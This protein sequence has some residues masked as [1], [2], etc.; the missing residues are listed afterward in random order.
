MRVSRFA[1]L[2]MGIWFHTLSVVS[3]WPDSLHHSMRYWKLTFQV[4]SIYMNSVIVVSRNLDRIYEEGGRRHYF[5]FQSSSKDKIVNPIRKEWTFLFFSFQINYTTFNFCIQPLC[6][7]TYGQSPAGNRGC[8]IGFYLSF[9]TRGSH[10]SFPA[11][12]D[13]RMFLS[14]RISTAEPKRQYREHFYS[15][16]VSA[17]PKGGYRNDFT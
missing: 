10:H 5:L 8:H 3:S 11:W 15:D 14:E 9:M 4:R 1:S 13:L 2:E 12:R 6:L 16:G 17:F 7:G